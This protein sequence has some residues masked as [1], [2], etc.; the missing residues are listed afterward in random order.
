LSTPQEIAFLP[1]RSY[2]LTTGTVPL[3]VSRSKEHYSCATY[4]LPYPFVTRMPPVSNL[5][6]PFDTRRTPPS[7]IC[8]AYWIWF[9]KEDCL[10]YDLVSKLQLQEELVE[11]GP[12]LDPS[13]LI[14]NE[15]FMAKFKAP[16]RARI[17]E[18]SRQTPGRLSGAPKRQHRRLSVLKN[19]AEYT[20]GMNPLYRSARNLLYAATFLSAF[21]ETTVY[22]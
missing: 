15:R 7:A 12:E 16:Y 21:I 11:N 1:G 20:I 17:G 2:W 5:L 10:L 4:R 9:N 22:K 8:S 13:L 19:C 6:L 18:F 3:F 14:A